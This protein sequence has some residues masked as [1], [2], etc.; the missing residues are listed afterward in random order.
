MLGDRAQTGETLAAY[1]VKARVARARRLIRE[2]DLNF[3]EISDRLGFDNPQYFSR[4]FKRVM[5][6][7]P[8][9]FR[10]SL[11]RDRN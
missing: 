7:T 5:G 6:M 8:S 4:V 9:E 3:A 2:G 10:R 11:D 1:A